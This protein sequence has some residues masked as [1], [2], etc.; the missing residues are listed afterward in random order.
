MPG[1]DT[2]TREERKPAYDGWARRA[3]SSHLAK[4]KARNRFLCEAKASLT[5]SPGT[6]I[7]FRAMR[8]TKDLRCAVNGLQVGTRRRHSKRGSVDASQQ[9]AARPSRRAA[10]LH[11]CPSGLVGRAHVDG[12]KITNS[13]RLMIDHDIAV[14][15]SHSAL[16][17]AIRSSANNVPL[18]TALG[19][20]AEAFLCQ[21]GTALG[22]QTTTKTGAR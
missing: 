6:A 7:S 15:S 1:T 22:M 21:P 5:Q 10:D 18:C 12:T 16:D 17:A 4:Q 19:P 8:N 11:D 14:Y 3:V 2:P 20:E 13:L 9:P